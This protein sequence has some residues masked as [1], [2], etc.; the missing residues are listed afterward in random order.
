MAMEKFGW[1]WR[2]DSTGR[3]LN[4]KFIDIGHD[5]VSDTL[6]NPNGYDPCEVRRSI[7]KF[8]ARLDRDYAAKGSK[9]RNDWDDRRS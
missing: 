9:W 3:K 2:Y 5:P 4:E 7:N 6:H 8:R 1:V